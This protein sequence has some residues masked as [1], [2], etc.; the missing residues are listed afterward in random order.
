MVSAVRSF[1][2]FLVSEG[3]T[4][5]GILAFLVAPR[6]GRR[7]PRVL[8]RQQVEALLAVPLGRAVLEIRDRA[9]LETLYASGA[10]ASEVCGLD[11]T[12]IDL[13]VGFMRCMGKG[14]RERIV[15]LGRFAVVAIGNYLA[16]ARPALAR[17]AEPGRCFLSRTGRALT[18]DALWRVV[19]KH[20]LAAGISINVSPHTLRHSFATHLLEGRADLRVVQEM[21][22]HRDIATTE[23]YTHVDREALKAEHRKFHPRG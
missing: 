13:K 20:A 8:S 4:G 5:D 21:L 11:V 7:L 3:C 1:Y 17:S 18:R 9:L 15:P 16:R 22:G 14:R 12:D 2:R 19:K 10:R 6:L 23:I